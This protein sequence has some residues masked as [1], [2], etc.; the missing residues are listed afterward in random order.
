MKKKAL[1]SFSRVSPSQKI[2]QI[3]PIGDHR[4]E[5]AH[6]WHTVRWARRCW[7]WWCRT[8]RKGS[9]R[10]RHCQLPRPRAGR[11]GSVFQPHAPRWHCQW[12]GSPP[13]RPGIQKSMKEWE[14]EC[15]QRQGNSQKQ[16][17]HW[18]QSL[19]I[20]EPFKTQASLNQQHALLKRAQDRWSD[21]VMRSYQP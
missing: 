16:A 4:W 21:L 9:R 17:H 15:R 1:Y 8:R 14:S 6:T 7:E 5:K 13:C 11:P 10:K 3:H 2:C 12:L 20:P 19:F 18:G